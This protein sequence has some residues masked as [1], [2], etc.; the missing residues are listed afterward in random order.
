MFFC[1]RL[2]REKV[3]DIPVVGLR[4]M[5]ERLNARCLR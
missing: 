5:G 4:C 3:Q 2:G 1:L